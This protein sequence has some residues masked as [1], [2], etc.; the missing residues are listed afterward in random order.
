MPIV[1]LSN[2][3]S[4]DLLSDVK[5]KKILPIEFLNRQCESL[6]LCNGQQHLDWRL[7]VATGSE[8]PRYVVLGF[9]QNKKNREK[10]NSAVFDHMNVRNAY[11]EFNGEQY[12]KSD[13]DL[14]F[15][16]NRYVA[17]YQ[18]LVDVYSN[19]SCPV[20]L[21][22]FKKLYPL[23]VFDLSH[24]LERLKDSASDIRIKANFSVNI[25]QNTWAYAL[26]LSDREI[27]MRSDGNR[28]SIIH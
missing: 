5:N 21:A 9:Q 2:E 6:Q 27:Q 12:P 13:L 22:S 4:M 3:A 11:V 7:S 28:M 15:A 8:R 26:V 20:S 25:P 16:N 23:L 18:M 17:G 10:A 19:V 14:D 1:K 24:Q